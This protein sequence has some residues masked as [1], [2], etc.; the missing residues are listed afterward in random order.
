VDVLR[1]RLEATG[2]DARD[3]AGARV[4]AIG[5]ATA[6]ALR[7]IGLCADLVPEPFTGAAVA[8]AFGPGPG[9]VLLPRAAEAPDDLPR[10]LEAKGWGC[11]VVAAYRTVEDATSAQAGRRALEEGVDAVLFTAGSTVRSFLRLWGPPPDPALV[12]CIGPVTAQAARDAGLRVDVVAGEHTIDGL[13]AA[14]VDA[15][16]R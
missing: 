14:L 2:R 8:E 13:V 11:D 12:C 3:F 16:R 10:A 5:P 9:R 15:V 6:A 1:E 4:A 7:T